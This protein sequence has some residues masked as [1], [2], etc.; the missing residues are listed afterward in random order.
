[1]IHPDLSGDIATEVAKGAPPAT[2]AATTVAGIIDWQT[3]V[4][5]LTAIYALMQIGWLGWKMLDKALGR[6]ERDDG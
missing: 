2:I 1:M 5:I 4:L 3:W 6:K